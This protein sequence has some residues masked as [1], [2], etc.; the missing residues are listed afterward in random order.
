[1]ARRDIKFEARLTVSGSSGVSLYIPSEIV[2]ILSLKDKVNHK[3]PC[4]LDSEGDIIVYA[5]VLS[6]D[7][8]DD[9]D[10]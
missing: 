5:T 10:E 2:K 8:E 6:G 7:D 1:M 3:V 9:E 4:I